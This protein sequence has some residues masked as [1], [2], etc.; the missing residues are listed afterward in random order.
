MNKRYIIASILL[1]IV[2]IIIKIVLGGFN[3]YNI[4]E[5]LP[6]YCIILILMSLFMM[7]IPTI[8]RIR[9]K[10][11]FEHKKGIKICLYNSLIIYILSLI[12]SITLIIREST[13]KNRYMMS[14]DTVG[15]AKQ[16]I[17]VFLGI[18]IIYYFINYLFYVE[19]RGNN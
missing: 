9:N 16:L 18:S 17:F 6:A 8:L 14:F 15:F 7:I 5:E 12:N 2:L 19:S 11:K 4:L 10:K 13:N 1:F 3:F